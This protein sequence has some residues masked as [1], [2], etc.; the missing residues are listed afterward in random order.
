MDAVSAQNKPLRFQD[1]EV[2]ERNTRKKGPSLYSQVFNYS[3]SLPKFCGLPVKCPITEVV[4][5]SF[6]TYFFVI[7]GCPSG[8]AEHGFPK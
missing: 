7:S 6:D 5:H 2:A 4:S 3:G 8:Y 1:E